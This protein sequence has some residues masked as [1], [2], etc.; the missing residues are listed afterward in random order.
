MFYIFNS[1]RPT[2]NAIKNILGV[3]FTL[4]SYTQHA[5]DGS[6]DAKAASYVSIRLDNEVYWGCGVDTDIG[7]SSVK[8]LVSAI[9]KALKSKNG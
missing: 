6:T 1:N 5:L 4:Q 7:E 2:S 9:N 8:A 3:N